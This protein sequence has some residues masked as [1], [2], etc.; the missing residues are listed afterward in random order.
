MKKWWR[1]WRTRKRLGRMLLVVQ[2]RK[3][4]LWRCIRELIRQN[5]LWE[6]S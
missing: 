4:G 6:A 2:E 3:P 1:R 5:D